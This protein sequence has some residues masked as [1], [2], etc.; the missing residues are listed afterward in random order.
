MPRFAANLSLLFTE[1]PLPERFARAA[2]A[3]FRAVEIQF[4]Y[5]YPAEQLADAAR[6]AGTQVL[7]INV[8]AGDLMTG[9]PGLAC[10]IGPDS[11]GVFIYEGFGKEV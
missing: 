8:A 5:D 11:V 2:D 4:P 3:G 10:Q 1:V 7:L 9:G 6:S